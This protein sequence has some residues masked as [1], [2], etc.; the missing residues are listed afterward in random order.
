MVFQTT[1]PHWRAVFWSMW[2]SCHPLVDF[3]E[4]GVEGYMEDWAIIEVDIWWVEKLS[5]C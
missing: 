2:F 5:Y 4:A 3:N 1:E